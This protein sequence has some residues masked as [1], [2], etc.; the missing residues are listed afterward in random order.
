ML[1]LLLAMLAVT[2][3]SPDFAWH[4]IDSHSENEVA[5]DR[6]ASDTYHHPDDGS[7]NDSAHS[8]IGH[9]LSHLP[10][11]MHDLAWPPVTVA[12][13]TAYPVCASVLICATLP[14]PFKPPRNITLI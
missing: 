10:A 4:M 6:H 11:V 8:Q 7:E 13:S 9:L 3:M 14:P 12:V 2:F 5:A 1:R